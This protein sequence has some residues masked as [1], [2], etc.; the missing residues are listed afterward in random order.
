MHRSNYHFFTNRATVSQLKK[1]TAWVSSVSRHKRRP[2]L[3]TRRWLRLALEC[4][5]GWL[6][7]WE[8]LRSLGRL[9]GPFPALLSDLGDFGN[10]IGKP[11]HPCYGSKTV[12]SCGSRLG[13]NEYEAFPP[14]LN[15]KNGKF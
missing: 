11:Y 5:L 3:A 12:L 15:W 7:C 8:S 13:P 1:L 4:R 10:T 9:T 2:N 6:L 14:L